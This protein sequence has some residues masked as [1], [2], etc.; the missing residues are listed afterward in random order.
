MTPRK[1][2]SWISCVDTDACASNPIQASP[3]Q[4]GHACRYAVAVVRAKKPFKQYSRS[5]RASVV[6]IFA[7]SLGLVAAAERDIQHRPGDQVRGSRALWRLVCLNALG[8][9]SY[10]RWGRRWTVGVPHA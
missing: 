4:L 1:R 3:E 2:T 7:V 10:F 9:A 6:V 5:Q 8:A